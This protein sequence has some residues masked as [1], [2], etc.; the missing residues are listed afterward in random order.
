MYNLWK[1]CTYE[2]YSSCC[3]LH[4]WICRLLTI[5]I[6][7]MCTK[8][9]LC[10]NLSKIF[11]HCMSTYRSLLAVFHSIL[12][13]QHLKSIYTCNYIT[14]HI[15]AVNILL[16]KLLINENYLCVIIWYK[17]L[18]KRLSSYLNFSWTLNFKTSVCG[19]NRWYVYRYISLHM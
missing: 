17:P 1:M 6:K 15:N 2:K 18:C 4:F 16:F 14:T 10:I 11:L 8:I 7:W 12:L 19:K 13:L 9:P 5:I 3:L